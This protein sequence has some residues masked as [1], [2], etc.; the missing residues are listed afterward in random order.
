MYLFLYSTLFFEVTSTIIRILSPLPFLVPPPLF[1][2]LFLFTAR[3]FFIG[4]AY[5]ICRLLPFRI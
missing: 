5:T 1:L 4:N 2:L 3:L